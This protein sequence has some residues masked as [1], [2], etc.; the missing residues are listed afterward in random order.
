MI[1]QKTRDAFQ[2]IVGKQPEETTELEAYQA[3]LEALS[4]LLERFQRSVDAVYGKL[5]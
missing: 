3:C 1:D 4:K 2:R 5:K